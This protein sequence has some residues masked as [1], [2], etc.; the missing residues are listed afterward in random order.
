MYYETITNFFLCEKV[1]FVL[2]LSL[3]HV[4][5]IALSSTVRKIR[6]PKLNDV[7]FTITLNAI[8]NTNTHQS[9]SPMH[10]HTRHIRVLLC[11]CVQSQ[12]IQ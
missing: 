4:D 10:P 5:K 6:E 8:R 9:V 12:K 7:K 1:Q 2:S 3:S 11:H